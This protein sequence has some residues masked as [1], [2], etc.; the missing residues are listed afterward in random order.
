M[1]LEET[2][3]SCIEKEKAGKKTMKELPGTNEFV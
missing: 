3:V 1:F 2:P